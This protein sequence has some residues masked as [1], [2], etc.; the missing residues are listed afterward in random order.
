MTFDVDIGMV[1]IL[2]LPKSTSMVKVID[3]I[4]QSQV[5]KSQEENIMKITRR[6]KGTVG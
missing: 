2:I 5:G 3:Q 4:S 1:F 6:D